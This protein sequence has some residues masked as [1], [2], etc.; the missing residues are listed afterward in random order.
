ALFGQEQLNYLGVS[1]GTPIGSTYADLFPAN[2]GR[3]GL[4]A[5]VAP[6]T[7]DFEGTLHQAAGFELAYGNFVADCLQQSDCTFDGDK[8]DALAQTREL[9]DRLDA[10]PITVNDGRQLGSGA[11]FIAIAANLYSDFQWPT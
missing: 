1:Y 9:I 2:V 6:D 4:D 7:T 5:A 11:L 8:A 3:M 10:N